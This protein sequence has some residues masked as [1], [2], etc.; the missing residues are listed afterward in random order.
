MEAANRHRLTVA[1]HA[2]GDAAADQ[3][4]S[5][6]EATGARGSIE[7]AQLIRREDAKRMAAAGMIASVQ[8]AHLLDDRDL[9]ERLWPDKCERCFALRWLLDEGV[10]LAMGSDAPVAAL[11]PWLAMAV[12]GPP[13]RR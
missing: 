7:H 13:H 3:A 8:P 5:A 6:F 1:I 12:G 4:L 2:I 10:T 11:D 9:T